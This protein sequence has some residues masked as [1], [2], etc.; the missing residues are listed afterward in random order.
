MVGKMPRYA[1]LTVTL[2][3]AIVMDVVL[4]LLPW[5]VVWKLNMKRSERLIVACGLSLGFL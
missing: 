3:Y 1:S 2:A 4:A 5:N